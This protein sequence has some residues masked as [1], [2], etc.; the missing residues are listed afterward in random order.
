MNM[1]SFFLSLPVALVLTSCSAPATE[2]NNP[3]NF[4]N[5]NATS[6]AN[7]ASTTAAPTGVATTANAQ[8]SGAGNSGSGASGTGAGAKTYKVIDEASPDM[9]AEIVAALK[10]AKVPPPP[11]TL[12]VADRQRVR[13]ITSKGTIVVELN[14]QAA[15]LHAKS[16][17]Y[18]AGRKFFD[19]TVFHRYVP[20]FVIQGG[21]PLTK[22][23]KFG[24]PYASMT[25]QPSGF[26]GTGGP[27]YQIPREYSNLT[28]EKFVLAAARGRDPDSAGSQF[29]ITLEA[30]PSLDKD[31]PTSVDP[32]GYTVFGK[33]VS[34]SDVVSKLRAGDKLQSA[35]LVK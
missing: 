27:G 14:P 19:G 18:L 13:L 20:G 17:A 25:G 6:S 28:H 10:K 30:Q 33:V 5:A 12:K 21:D 35:T 31:T 1:K 8:T 23:P 7:N 16:F 24:A 2:D 9:P 3:D 11:A 29:Y 4:L 34:G 32:N 22:N 26:H 15:P